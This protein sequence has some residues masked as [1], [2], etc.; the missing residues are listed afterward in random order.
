MMV[1][2]PI[3]ARKTIK[4]LEKIL[5][6]NFELQFLG[7]HMDPNQRNS[8]VA[9]TAVQ[10]AQIHFVPLLT[11]MGEKIWAALVCF[12]TIYKKRKTPFPPSPDLLKTAKD[13]REVTYKVKIHIIYTQF[14]IHR[15]YGRT[16]SQSRQLLST[17][18]PAARLQERYK[19][20]EL[21]LFK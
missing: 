13:R 14:E 18:E 17:L 16:K 20:M 10:A 4:A 11:S 1:L 3:L 19:I 21:F 12:M 6:N 15:V 8:A 9:F 7:K 5:K 2:T